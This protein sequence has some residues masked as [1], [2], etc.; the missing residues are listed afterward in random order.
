MSA[1]SDLVKLHDN[2]IVASGSMDTYERI[3]AYGEC[4]VTRLNDYEN[5]VQPTVH[6]RRHCGGDE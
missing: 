1:L 5:T 6:T 2:S 4:D 3:D